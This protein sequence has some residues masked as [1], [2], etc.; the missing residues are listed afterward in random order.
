MI[1]R[2]GKDKVVSGQPGT[3]YGGPQAEPLTATTRLQ[4][5]IT[6]M[7]NDRDFLMQQN[8][9]LMAMRERLLGSW[10][11]SIEH[12]GMPSSEGSLSELET[13]ER[14]CRNVAESIREHIAALQEAI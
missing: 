2:V 13:V 7:V 4:A 9:T 6:A 8:S 5:L 3:L 10:P 1:P 12:E 11:T 14:E